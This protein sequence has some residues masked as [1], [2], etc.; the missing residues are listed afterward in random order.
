MPQ[1]APREGS[2]ASVVREEIH[3]GEDARRIGAVHRL[4]DGADEPHVELQRPSD[5]EG[6][7]RERAPVHVQV[8]PP[9][10]HRR[11]DPGDREPRDDPG[12]R[13]W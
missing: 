1:H 10:R 5:V 9:E 6:A 3:R 13:A 2:R 8:R 7:F 4:D 12:E 11:D